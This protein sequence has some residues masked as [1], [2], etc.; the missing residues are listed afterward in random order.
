MAPDQPGGFAS[1]QH[2]SEDRDA[3]ASDGRRI[4]GLFDRGRLE[5]ASAVSGKR[6]AAGRKGRTVVSL[7]RG[8][9]EVLPGIDPQM[10]GSIVATK[11]PELAARARSASGGFGDIIARHASAN[12]V[13]LPLAQAVIRVESNFRVNARGRA[14]EVGLMQIKPATARGLGYSGST[15]ALYDP[16]TNIRWGMKYLGIAHRLAG[17]STCRTILKYNAGHGAKRMNPVSAAYCTKVKRQIEG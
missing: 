10:T 9:T 12:G 14:G 17:G 11:P 15:K 1:A 6:T 8:S 16:E 7:E 3:A 13:P 4:G 2:P 5:V